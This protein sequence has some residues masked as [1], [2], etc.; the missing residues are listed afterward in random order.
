MDFEVIVVGAGI[1]GSV[2]ACSLAK[3]GVE[4]CLIDSKNPLEIDNA[5]KFPSRTTAQLEK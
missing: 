3:Q 5:S 4:V 1:V 2:L